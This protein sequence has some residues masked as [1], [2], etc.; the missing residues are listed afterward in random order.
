MPEPY[1]PGHLLGVL[2]GNTLAEG[3]GF[4]PTESCPSHA[5]EACPFGRSGTL[6]CGRLTD[7]AAGTTSS[8]TQRGR[9]PSPL[10]T[11]RETLKVKKLYAEEL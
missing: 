7:M 8:S 11:N 5:F 4:E 9:L 3:V 10:L 2:A 1:G 6:P